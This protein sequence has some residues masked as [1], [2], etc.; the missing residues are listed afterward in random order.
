LD[1]LQPCYYADSNRTVVIK[2]A[3]Q[4]RLGM[5]MRQGHAT[6]YSP[7]VYQNSDMYQAV[8]VHWDHNG[9]RLPT[10]AEWEAAYRAGDEATP[11]DYPWPGGVAAGTNYGWLAANSGDRTQPVGLLLTNTYGLYDLAGNVCEWTWD[12]Q[13]YNYYQAHNP[14]G[15]ET[16]DFFGKVVRG[17]CF[18]GVA[19]RADNRDT[20][21]QRESETR[22]IIG[23]RV[24]RCD[25]DV[26][27]DTNIFIAPI[28]LNI[29]TAEYRRLDGATHRGSLWRQGV[30][31]VT[32]AAAPFSLKWSFTTGSNV[33]SSP[34]VWQ[35]VVYVGSDD[36]KVYALDATTG[37]QRWAFAANA[38]LPVRSSAT[39]ADGF[40]YMG[41]QAGSAA[42]QYGYL[43]KL[44]ATV[45]TQCWQYRYGTSRVDVDTSPA[46]NFGVVFARHG[47]TFNGVAVSNGQEVWRYRFHTL[48][49]GPLGPAMDGGILY[50][51]GADNLHFAANV[52]D[53]QELWYKVGNHC[54]ACIVPVDETRHL[55]VF[56][57]AASCR[58]RQT[59]NT[60]WS[61]SFGS[62][63]DVTPYCTPAVGPVQL[64][65]NT[66]NLVFACIQTNL[67]AMDVNNGNKLWQ[68]THTAEFRSSP[69]LVGNMLF[70]G[71]DD[72]Y[73]YALN[74]ATGAI[75]WQYKTGGMV[76][77]SPWID[78]QGVLYVGSDDGR[79]Y[80]LNT[81]VPEPAVGGMLAVLA[82]SLYAMLGR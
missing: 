6:W 54:G 13:N 11:M 48:N 23:L 72:G 43:Y 73:I 74:A 10:S 20:N 45:G 35:G 47:G 29:N 78:A 61:K 64:G 22:P 17:A 80:A 44:D 16:P 71:C 57:Y 70:L 62:G 26:H 32:T 24:V 69:S 27:P 46:V 4:W 9:Y 58:N 34:V 8:F 2:N 5:E 63:L 56:G 12:W 21:H 30:F 42:G 18:G 59:G 65:A 7:S 41:N 81:G 53:E 55:Y 36:G 76:C 60:I 28:V 68:W 1:G 25:T 38:N 82:T 15:T 52:R 66:S 67:I 14:K 39:I 75:I 49:K 37:T 40:V 79:V 33:F 50:A 77:S 31:P 19:V 51:P 3:N